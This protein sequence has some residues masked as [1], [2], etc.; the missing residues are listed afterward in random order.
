MLGN[1][2][3]PHVVGALVPVFRCGLHRV[4]VELADATGGEDRRLDIMAV[5]Q[6][7]E[8]P[9]ADPA[10]ELALGEL[11]RRLVQHAAQQ[12][13]VEIGGAAQPQSPAPGPGAILSDTLSPTAVCRPWPFWRAAISRD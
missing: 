7:D 10:A 12:H 5:E 2:V 11:H 3:L 4:R 6:L 1:L 8:A 13:S 9:D